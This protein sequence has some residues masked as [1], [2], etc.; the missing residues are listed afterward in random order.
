[1]R[2]KLIINNQELEVMY[3]ISRNSKNKTIHNQ[4]CRYAK[5]I[6]PENRI[7]FNKFDKALK[8]GNSVCKHCSFAYTQYRKNEKKLKWYCEKRQME[9]SFGNYGIDIH[10]PYGD[11]IVVQTERKHLGLYHKNTENKDGKKSPIKDYHFQDETY[12][13][14]KTLIRY[15]YEHDRYMRARKDNQKNKGKKQLNK[16]D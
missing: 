3:V 10:T 12:Y 6:K 9:I 4:H 16:N 13:E 14:I 11:W 5:V 7:E 2:W 8:A 1:M 15:I